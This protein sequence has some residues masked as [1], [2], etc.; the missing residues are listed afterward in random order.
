MADVP[1]QVAVRL[2]GTHVTPSRLVALRP[3]DVLR[4]DHRADEPLELVTADVVV[5]NAVSGSRGQRLAC[6]VVEK[7]TR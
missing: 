6:L 2:R 7:E 1:V 3:G 4:L 5:G